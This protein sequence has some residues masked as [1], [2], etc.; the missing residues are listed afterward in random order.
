[1]QLLSLLL[2]L[3]GR[4]SHSKFKIPTPTLEKSVCNIEQGFKASEL[5]KK[6]ELII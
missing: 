6:V 4:T 5:L 3:G 2:L 1:V